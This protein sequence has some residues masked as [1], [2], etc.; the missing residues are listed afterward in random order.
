MTQPAT[1]APGPRHDSICTAAAKVVYQYGYRK[2]SMEAIAAAAGVSRQ[3][4]Y[5]QYRNKEALFHAVLEHVTTQM[6]REV[7]AIAEQPRK[8]TA[9]TLLA[10]FESLCRDTLEQTSRANRVEVLEVARSQE[11]ALYNRVQNAL[12]AVIAEVLASSPAMP[13]WERDGIS[14]RDLAAH[15]LDVSNGIKSSAENLQ[16]YRARMSL[17][18]RIVCARERS[19]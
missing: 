8:S 4:L 2:T 18:I 14:A 5:L 6:L 7:R 15:L 10:I 13:A 17:A 16:E 1:P 3:T 9:R 11:G 12:H 19:S